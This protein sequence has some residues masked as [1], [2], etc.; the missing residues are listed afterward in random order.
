MII[1][2]GELSAADAYFAMT[3]TVM[4]RPVA[5]VLSTNENGS[6][7][8]APFSFFN[9][10]NSDPPLLVYSV[11]VQP[12]GSPKDTVVNIAARPE[13]VVNI[14]SVGQLHELNQT[15]AT[16]PYGESEVEAN[17]IALAD[18]EGFSL[19]RIAGSKIAMMCSRHQI[20]TI[21]NKGQSLIF[22]EIKS[23]D[24]DDQCA[25]IT[26]KGRLKVHADRVEPLARLG[27]GEYASFGEIL[28]ASRP[29]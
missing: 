12:D 22:G 6:F 1:D 4:P 7:N 25:E 8:L 11:G 29:D 5:W 24:L 9:A 23:I 26:D 3:Q 17:Q 28:E 20:Q 15:S 19:P 14:A 16:L 10:I 2:M 18:V 21:G 13:F 27:A